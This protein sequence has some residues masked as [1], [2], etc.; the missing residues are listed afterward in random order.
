MRKFIG[1]ALAL[2]AGQAQAAGFWIPDFTI[3]NL[4]VAGGDNYHFRVY[5][6]QPVSAC[7]AEPTMAYLN[8]KDSGS[9]GQIGTLLMVYST[10]KTVRFFVEPDANGYCH[11]LEV[12]VSG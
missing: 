6:M 7:S 1:V 9:K 12:Y 5:G 3:T 4:F 10:G 8:E 11:I 2:F